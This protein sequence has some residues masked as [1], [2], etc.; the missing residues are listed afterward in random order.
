MDVWCGIGYR[1][2]DM[3]GNESAIGNLLDFDVAG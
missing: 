2:W 1:N 3:V